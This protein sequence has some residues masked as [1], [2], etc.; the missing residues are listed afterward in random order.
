MSNYD[1]AILAYN[2]WGITTPLFHLSSSKRNFE[3]PSAKTQAHA[4][5]SW[6]SWNDLV[7][8]W[9]SWTYPLDIDLESKQKNLAWL[10]LTES[11]KSKS[12]II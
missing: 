11:L 9:D 5:W 1:A 3:D 10:R 2:T 12:D 8:E 7:P 4:D 6:E